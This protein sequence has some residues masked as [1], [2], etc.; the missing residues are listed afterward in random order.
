MKKST[1]LILSVAAIAIAGIGGYAL[2]KRR[3]GA[4][5]QHTKPVN[6]SVARAD[7]AELP[8][9]SNLR[10]FEF[11]GCSGDWEEDEIVPQAWRAGRK[12]KTTFLVRH[13]ADCGYTVGSDPRA[14]I[15]GTRIDLSYSMSNESGDIA[16]CFCE[17]WAAFELRSL[18]AR[19]TKITINGQQAKLMGDLRER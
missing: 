19:I 6:G 9:A 10:S 5:P 18:P 12:N 13:P 14:T 11:L 3:N 2:S 17:Y 1:V 4:E 8:A 16:A 15:S 7:A